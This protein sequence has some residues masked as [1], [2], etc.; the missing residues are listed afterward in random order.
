MAKPKAASPADSP[1]ADSELALI[2]AWWRACNYLSVGMI[3]LQDNALLA[4]PLKPE[5]VKQRLL[6]HW[7][8]SPA[9]SFVW[10]HLNRVIKR[11]DV[12][13]IFMAGPGHGAPGVL[14][15]T[16][17]DGTYSEIYPD[18]YAFRPERFLEQP[19]GTYT[20]IPFGGGRRRC[21]GAPFAQ[22]EMR[23][24]LRALLERCTLKSAGPAMRTRRRGIAIR[25]PA[26]SMVVL[27]S[28]PA[29]GASA[30]IQ[31]EAPALA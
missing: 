29:S 26:D 7:G 22:L 12:D 9:L 24:V 25:P 30:E 18:P 2:D 13:V 21:I 4:E 3:Y 15:P 6:G 17:L 28:R 5:H 27:Y 14:G 19:P 31:G 16:Y 11:D 1:L 8:A 10:A 23:L 20:W